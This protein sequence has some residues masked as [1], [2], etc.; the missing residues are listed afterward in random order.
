MMWANQRSW[1]KGADT[2]IVCKWLE[3]KIPR[4]EADYEG[5]HDEHLSQL[6]RALVEGNSFMSAL[7]H[8]PL[9]L[10][11]SDALRISNHGLAFLSL[12][13]S[14]AGYAFQQGWPRY[15]LQPKFHMLAHILYSLRD[16]GS[17]NIETLNPIAFSCQLDEDFIGRVATLSR[18]VSSRTIHERTIQR[19]LL[20]VA[21]RW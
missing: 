2:T 19:F 18:T 3:W 9:W 16:A 8:Q 7:Y 4:F 21:S 14:L 15:K 17:K 10:K 6:S 1:F 5:D 11:P 12:Y 20:N 13:S